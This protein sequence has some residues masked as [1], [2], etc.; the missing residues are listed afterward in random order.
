MSE[1]IRVFVGCA[2]NADDL[3]S[4]AVLEYTLRK[5]ASRPLEITWMRL[6]RDPASPFYSDGKKG[7][8]TEAWSTPFSGFRWC[9]PELC[10][11][12]GRAIY[13][14]SDII[15]HA[16][17]GELWDQEFKPG[18]VVLAKG[19][20]DSWRFCVSLWD[21]SR[22]ACYVPM[23]A[24]LW[25]AETHR[26]MVKKFC[27][28]SFVQGFVGAWNC[29]DGEDFASLDDPRI[30][31]LHYSDEAHQPQLKHAV[32]RLAKEERRHWFDGT[33]KPHWR[34][35]MQELFDRLLTEAE[36]AGFRRENYRPETLFGDYKKQSH[37][38]GYRGHRWSRAA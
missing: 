9:V 5:H 10:G 15:V 21:A 27:G 8:Q 34:K 38:A 36:A 30:K 28:A 18:K 33:A 35:D 2:P 1:A 11:F 23:M 4:Q 7:W 6:S 29:I 25:R 20:Q 3:E 37:K 17:I 16:D 32:P 24:T 22:A 14:D 19:G 13:M 12:E 31:A 26:N